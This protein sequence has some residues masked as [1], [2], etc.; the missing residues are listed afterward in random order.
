MI[1]AIIFD[2][3]GLILDTETPDF[4]SWR[5]TFATFNCDLSLGVWAQHIGTTTF[6]PFAYLESLLGHAVDR[7]AVH[8]QRKRLDTQL[9]AQQE[10]LPGVRN[11]LDEAEH[12]GLKIG[13]ASSS[14]HSWVDPHL[15]RLGLFDRFAT[16]CCA[17]DVGGRSKPDPAVY[18]LAIERLAIL[19]QQGI[20]LED[21]VNGVVAGKGA[22]L[23]VTAV[24]NP[25][26]HHLNFEQADLRM[27][28]MTEMGL[29]ELIAKLRDND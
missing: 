1:K 19:P 17:D 21:S 6:D 29:A 11:Y 10:V 12:L 24:P 18:T 4:E 15:T 5:Q 8:Q 22:G 9:I 25:M 20:A 26:T 13:L 14:E 16:I 7:Q 2:F 27:D 28:A 3:D 23:W